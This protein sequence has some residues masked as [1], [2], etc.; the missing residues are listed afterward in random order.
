MAMII[1]YHGCCP[2]AA[3]TLSQIAECHLVDNV[4]MFWLQSTAS[5]C[6]VVQLVS[7]AC[8]RMSEVGCKKD[9]RKRKGSVEKRKGQHYKLMQLDVITL[10]K[11]SC[12]LRCKRQINTMRR[13]RLYACRHDKQNTVLPGKLPFKFMNHVNELCGVMTYRIT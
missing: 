9:Y 10:L 2:W 12:V 3:C 4:I 6:P 13:V 8:W 5:R 11:L 7:G 1:I